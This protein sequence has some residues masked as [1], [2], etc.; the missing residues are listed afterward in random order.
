MPN[1][2]AR[3][4]VAWSLAGANRGKGTKRR[5]R[6]KIRKR[7]EKENGQKERMGEKE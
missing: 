3:P 1:I 6:G 2:F 4:R 5:R 7:K